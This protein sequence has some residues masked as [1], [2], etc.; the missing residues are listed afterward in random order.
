MPKRKAPEEPPGDVSSEAQPTKKRLD[1]ASE[2]QSKAKRPNNFW[3]P[4]NT[5]WQD[6]HDVD[7]KRPLA[8]QIRA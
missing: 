7:G 1:N 3:A 2:V 6:Q 5:W 8:G 4:F